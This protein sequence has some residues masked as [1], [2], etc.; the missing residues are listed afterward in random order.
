MIYKCR[1]TMYDSIAILV[2]TK[3]LRDSKLTLSGFMCRYFEQWNR[4]ESG[5]ITRIEFN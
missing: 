5:T 1:K 3:D 2:T 4:L